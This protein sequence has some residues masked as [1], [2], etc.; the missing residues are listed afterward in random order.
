MKLVVTSNV[1][2]GILCGKD[3]LWNRVPLILKLA[4]QWWADKKQEDREAQKA[5]LI[6]HILLNPRLS[7][8]QETISKLALHQWQ[9][10]QMW[11][12][13]SFSLVK[14]K[15]QDHRSRF[16]WQRD[17]ILFSDVFAH[18]TSS[19]FLLF[20]FS[21]FLRLNRLLFAGVCLVGASRAPRASLTRA[22]Q[23][24]NNYST[25][26]NL[27]PISTNRSHICT[28]ICL[29]WRIEDVESR[30]VRGGGRVG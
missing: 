9:W 8:L 1:T 11:Y 19:C 27:S 12:S 30:R 24:L 21:Y 16:P 25:E 18:L 17:K 23:R 15:G 22:Q 4:Q 3:Q 6:K 28:E 14:C 26:Y 7:H 13:S 2:E 29:Y 20:S 10:T 5:I